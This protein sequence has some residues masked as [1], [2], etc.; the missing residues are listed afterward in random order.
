MKRV[1]L[2]CSII[3]AAFG[4]GHAQAT[5]LSVN[6]HSIARFS[7]SEVDYFYYKILESDGE[8]EARRLWGAYHRLRGRCVHNPNAHGT[9][10]VSPEI[11]SIAAAY[12]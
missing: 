11:A 4:A 5:T 7:S 2:S 1:L 3:L 12:R 10:N 9:V 6:C 8:A